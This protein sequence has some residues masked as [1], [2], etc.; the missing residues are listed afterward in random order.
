MTVCKCSA[1]L[2]FA[3]VSDLTDTC[4]MLSGTIISSVNETKHAIETGVGARRTEGR[5]DPER[6]GERQNQRAD[7]QE[8]HRPNLLFDF[9]NCDVSTPTRPDSC[10]TG[11]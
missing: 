6:G 9:K 4:A 3:I 7:L 10:R 11:W 1:D 2:A 8:S 5:N